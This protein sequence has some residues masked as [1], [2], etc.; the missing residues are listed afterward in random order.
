LI[1]C[2]TT[3]IITGIIAITIPHRTML[4]THVFL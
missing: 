3:N 2:L 4:A 1:V